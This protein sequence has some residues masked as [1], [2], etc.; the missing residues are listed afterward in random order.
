MKSAT[1]RI[2]AFNPATLEQQQANFPVAEPDDNDRGRADNATGTAKRSSR[3][4][5]KAARAATTSGESSRNETI[6]FEDALEAAKEA[7]DKGLRNVTA[8]LARI[9]PELY[10][11]LETVYVL[12][13]SVVTDPAAYDAFVKGYGIEPEHKRGPKP[14]NAYQPLLAYFFREYPRTIKKRATRYGK[15][16]EAARR[17]SISTAKGKVVEFLKKQGGIERF[18]SANATSESTPS[19][20]QTSEAC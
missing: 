6:P 4:V 17:D 15:A 16:L 1:A 13:A 11:A 2:D 3:G 12:Q 18:S 5:E 8:A 7:F 19:L 14:T 20:E 10:E 9:D